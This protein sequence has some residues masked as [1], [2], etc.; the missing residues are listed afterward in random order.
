M[1]GA[2]GPALPWRPRRRVARAGWGQAGKASYGTQT[3]LQTPRPVG[4]LPCSILNLPSGPA[5]GLAVPSRH[6]AIHGSTHLL[7]MAGTGRTKGRQAGTYPTWGGPGL[8]VCAGVLSPLAGRC[9]GA[10]APVRWAVRHAA[11]SWV[12]SDGQKKVG[13]QLPDTQF[14]SGLGLWCQAFV[15]RRK[16][17]KDLKTTS[18]TQLCLIPSSASAT[19]SFP[20]IHQSRILRR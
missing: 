10:Q 6:R 18:I 1:R 9:P 17:P 19:L 11:A 14:R 13:Q 16:S 20:E 3:T 12:P 5:P 15:A 7:A 8:G 4:T 2:R